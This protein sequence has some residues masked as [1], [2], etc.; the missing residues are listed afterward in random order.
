MDADPV[1][2]FSEAADITGQLVTAV[3]PE[4]WDNPTPC[5]GW[6][7]RN[8]VRHLINGQY[9]FAAILHGKPASAARKDASPDGELPGSY[10]DSGAALLAAFRQPGILRQVFTVPIGPVPGVVALHLRTTELLVHGWDL[11]RATGQP[12]AFPAALAESEL[13]FSRGMLG[14][15]PPG[16]PSFAAPQPVP[17]D[18]PAIDRLAACLGRS[19]TAGSLGS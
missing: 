19:M 13:A 6:D 12:A 8:L 14:S 3:R 11:A 10:R 16:H 1:G 7:V 15:I 5:P 9:V 18:A 2:Q 17:D 4:Q